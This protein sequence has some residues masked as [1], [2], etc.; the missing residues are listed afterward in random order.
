MYRSRNHREKPCLISCGI[1]RKEI[2]HLLE[3]GD[4]DAEV[5]FL[6]ENLHRDYNLLDRALNHALKKYRMQGSRDVIVVYGDVCLGF[7]GEM[8][9]LID[10]YHVVKVD[11]LNCIDCMLGGKG[12]LLEIDP[13][14]KYLFLNPAFI[15]FTEKIRQETKE[16]TREM[17]SMLDG[18]VLLDTMGDLDDYQS[19]IDEM[20]DHTGLPI[21]ERKDIGLGG[22]KRILLEALD[23]S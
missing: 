6:S 23:G 21:L 18:I 16:K 8:K 2:N 14:H 11:A 5:H 13:D 19:K 12:K 15:R 20:A 7:N 3:K 10:R 1:L 9:A 17:F 4:I 22:L